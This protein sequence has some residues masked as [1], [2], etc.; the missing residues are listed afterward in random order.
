MKLLPRLLAC[1]ALLAALPAHAD[2]ALAKGCKYVNI[3]SVPL[4]YTGP[5]LELTMEGSL[6]GTPATWLVDTGASD[7]ALTRTG[8]EPRD[9]TLWNTGT[10]V[11]GVGGYSRVYNTRFKEFRVGPVSSRPGTLRVISDFGTAPAQ[12]GIIGA[13]FLLQAD[14]EFSLAE[15]Q[16]RFFRPLDCRNDF[17]AYWD[18]QA[19]VLPFERSDSRSPNPH[20]TVLLNGKKLN[21]IIDSGATTTLVTL[22]AASA[23]ASSSTRPA[24]NAQATASAS[25]TP[26]W[27]AG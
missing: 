23:P 18:P 5:G 22:D 11:R 3:A 12:D 26:W 8:T 20:F 17:L 14:L 4:R 16:I 7:T 13:P 21:A 2:E 27:R 1:V 10:S 6:N 19:T 24:S 15:K 9:M 25:A